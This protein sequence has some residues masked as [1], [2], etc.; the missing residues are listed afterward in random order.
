MNRQK[1]NMRITTTAK[2][3]A[4][5]L[6]QNCSNNKCEKKERHT[7]THT[8]EMKKKINPFAGAATN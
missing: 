2:K 7:R 8:G 3:N 5:Q 1:C 4:F 6:R